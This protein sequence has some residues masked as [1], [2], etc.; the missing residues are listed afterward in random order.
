MRKGKCDIIRSGKKSEVLAGTKRKGYCT[1][2][3]I[4]VVVK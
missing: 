2:V 3:R 1:S 4:I